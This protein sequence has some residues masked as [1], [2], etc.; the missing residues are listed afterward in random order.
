MSVSALHPV[1]SPASPP[2]GYLDAR[3]PRLAAWLSSLL[4][5]AA[6]L[7]GGEVVLCL[8][9]VSFGLGALRG[10]HAT[11]AAALWRLLRRRGIVSPPG[12]GALFEP[13]Q[14]LRAAQGVGLVCA[15]LALGGTWLGLGLLAAAA[16]AAACAA[17]LLNATT[18]FCLGCRAFALA[19]R[20]TRRP[21][22]CP[23]PW[24]APA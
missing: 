2:P 9:L 7:P 24:R 6:W 19:C 14:P 12:P 21:A 15:A 17:A 3:A 20:L 1:L 13:P 22:A 5:L 11:P 10:P 23:L 4:L 18:G 16:L 8:A